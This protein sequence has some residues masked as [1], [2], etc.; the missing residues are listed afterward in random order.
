MIGILKGR[1]CKDTKTL[2]EAHGMTGIGQGYTTQIKES[3]S[4]P[5]ARKSVEVPF[6]GNMGLPPLILDSKE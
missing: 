3:Q 1:P 5:T 4:P 2:R 6:G